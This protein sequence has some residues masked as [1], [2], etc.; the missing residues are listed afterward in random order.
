MTDMMGCSLT[1]QAPSPALRCSATASRGRSLY[2]CTQSRRGLAFLLTAPDALASGPASVNSLCSPAHQ[3]YSERSTCACASLAPCRLGHSM[4]CNCKLG[5]AI[6][7]V[8]DLWSSQDEH[9]AGAKVAITHTHFLA[10]NL[11][12]AELGWLADVSCSPLSCLV[13]SATCCRLRSLLFTSPRCSL[14]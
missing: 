11:S 5:N 9:S 8:H 13:A 1:R 4:S 12:S 7:Q 2:K 3:S 6:G 10:R 14:K